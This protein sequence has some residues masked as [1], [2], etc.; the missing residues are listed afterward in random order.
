MFPLLLAPVIKG[1][2]GMIGGSSKLAEG[3]SKTAMK[4]AVLSA[5]E[6]DKVQGNLSDSDDDSAG[7]KKKSE[8]KSMFGGLDLGRIKS[9]IG[10]SGEMGPMQ[11]V[12][13]GV[14]KQIFEVNKSMLS[15]LQRMET[16]MKLLLEVEYERIKGMVS[17]DASEKLEKGDTDKKTKPGKPGLLGRAAKGAGKVFGGIKGGLG[18]NIGKLLGLGGLLFLFKNFE[19]E[20]KVAVQKML[21][22]FGDVY[23]YFTADDFT[24]AMFKEDLVTKFL[25]KIKEMS[26]NIL[27]FIWGAIKGVA[28]EW[29]FGTKGDKR[30]KE[31]L[32]ANVK[33][34]QQNLTK[35]TENLKG[36]EDMTVFQT[37][38]KEFKDANPDFT[39]KDRANINK[40]HVELIEAF[41][42]ISQASSGRIQFTGIQD[43]NG[44]FSA[45]DIASVTTIG[46]AMNAQPIV[47]GEIKDFKFLETINLAKSG[48]IT[49]GMDD[50]KVDEINS[51][52]AD[53]T[54]LM[55]QYVKI[56]NMPLQKSMFGFGIND[57]AERKLE[58]DRLDKQMINQDLIIGNTGQVFAD[59][60]A[61]ITGVDGG[62]AEALIKVE[63]EKKRLAEENAKDNAKNG[64]LVSIQNEGAKTFVDAKQ[65]MIVPLSTQDAYQTAAFANIR[66]T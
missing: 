40:Q 1:I 25:P 65:Q 23:L 51:A 57:E 18:G 30:I 56:K 5:S 19:E 53:K 54:S 16:T 20:V 61:T 36:F 2:T 48:G 58:L 6:D 35:M 27:D 39:K 21:K 45:S 15:S 26:L 10:D 41:Q 17:L 47:D 8:Q 31:E 43:L 52:L 29:L 14:Y 37:S 46:A 3:A 13:G 38:S 49:K 64:G 60:T 24:F 12:K 44:R 59:T 9:A 63:A 22:F 55:Q 32:S 34:A 66:T 4:A 11:E 50:D 33:P 42:A 7:K 62:S 28:N